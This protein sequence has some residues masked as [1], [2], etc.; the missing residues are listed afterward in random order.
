MYEKN[1][2]SSQKRRVERDNRRFEDYCREYKDEWCYRDGIE[3][4]TG[5]QVG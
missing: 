1:L 3:T 5:V 4:I 2:N